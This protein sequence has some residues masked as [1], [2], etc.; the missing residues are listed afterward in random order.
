MVTNLYVSE[1]N[2]QKKGILGIAQKWL[3]N[4][5]IWHTILKENAYRGITASLR[6]LPDFIIIGGQKCGTTTLYDYLIQ[7]PSVIS[8]ARKEVHFFDNDYH[9]AMGLKRYRVQFP[10]NSYKNKIKKRYN[11][12]GITGEAS[13]NY[14]S[15]PLVP[16]RI[17]ESIPLVKLIVIL[18]NPV[19]RAY[20]E[21]H[22]N[23]RKNWENNSFEE[24]IAYEQKTLNGK[25]ENGKWDM[26]Y[27]TYND[28]RWPYLIRGIYVEHFRRWLD[29]FRKTQL[30]ILNTEDFKKNY[31]K[32]MK[33]CFQF[34][35]V[36]D[37]KV[38]EM[39]EKNVGEYIP[40]KLETREFLIDY[41]KPHN[42]RLYKFLNMK[43]DW[44]K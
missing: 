9:Y 42:E 31:S 27:R 44:D 33:S 29:V 35:G 34:L 19:D 8:A 10:T 36:S 12:Q 22:M 25:Y 3:H 43:F 6:T 28:K 11:N 2:L 1:T 13:P 39:D 4:H 17:F 23:R 41:F 14:L 5:P 7:H 26:K 40:M 38:K 37:Y 16:K 30:F 32:T 24:A 18:R 20:S 21:Y 15:H